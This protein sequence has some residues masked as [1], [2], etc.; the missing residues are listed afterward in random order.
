MDGVGIGGRCV[1]F[2]GIASEVHFTGEA[3]AYIGELVVAEDAQGHGIGQ[4][5]L[6]AAESWARTN[7]YRVVALDTGAANS[8]ARTFYARQGYNEESIK[9]AKV[10]D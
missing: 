4:C 2:V 3:Q 9:L 5:L 1:G 8:R 6:S 7:R 10:L